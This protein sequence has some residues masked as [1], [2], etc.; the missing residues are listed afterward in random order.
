MI[1]SL[2]K[3]QQIKKNWSIFQY[4]IGWSGKPHWE[5]RLNLAQTWKDEGGSCANSY[6]KNIA[7]R[8]DSQCKGPDTCRGLV[9]VRSSEEASTEEE[10]GG[11][12][13]EVRWERLGGQMV[14]VLM[15]HGEDS[16]FYSES[17]GS[18]RRV[19]SRGEPWSDLGF[20][21][22]PLDAL[23]NTDCKVE[24][25]SWGTLRR[26]LLQWFRWVT[27]VLVGEVVKSG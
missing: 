25:G 20:N 27:L 24:G 18:H 5:R 15:G 14:Q 17:Q 19:M 12:W 16:G 3:W 26:R 7:G 10:S 22:L 8:E 6:R 9:S 13:Q 11:E 23:R 1:G 4:V 21:K 2:E